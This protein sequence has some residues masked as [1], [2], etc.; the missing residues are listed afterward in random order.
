MLRRLV[1]LG[2]LL[3][4]P[5]GAQQ[6]IDP[7]TWFNAV[8]VPRD[9][10]GRVGN[11]GKLVMAIDADKD[12]QPVHCGIV[13]TSGLND[14]DAL[15]CA[16]AMKRARWTPLRDS[17]GQAVPNTYRVPVDW[18][19]MVKP[20]P[21]LTLTPRAER[22]LTYGQTYDQMDLP[23]AGAIALDV[24]LS[25]DGSATQ[26]AARA[27]GSSGSAK[28][29][30]W[31]CRRVLLTKP[32]ATVNRNGAPAGPMDAVVS[33]SWRV[34]GASSLFVSSINPEPG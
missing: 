27:G 24:V 26:C 14:L 31:L 19:L 7:G 4:A 8:D 1:G 23:P 11:G 2:L 6:R 10:M 18:R 34:D 13:A 3:A 20:G 33:V 25:S 9:M 5:A 21:Q 22:L 32:F 16:L 30:A 17:A 29:D 12:G 28:F 15:T